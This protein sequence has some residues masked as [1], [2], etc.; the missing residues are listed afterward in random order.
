MHIDQMNR[1]VRIPVAP[2]RII[3]LVPSQTEFLYDIGLGDRLVGVTKF[4][5][6][7]EHIRQEKSIVGG[8]K[9]FKI[10]RIR[11]L[12][13][14]LIIGNKEENIKHL[15]E[16]LAEEFPVWMSDIKT[17]DDATEMMQWVGEIT[18]TISETTRIVEKIHQN[19]N[20][21]DEQ[22]WSTKRVAYFIWK[23]P[24]M[25]AGE[26]NIITHLMGRLKWENVFSS[27]L[28]F[29]TNGN[30]RYPS[31]KADDLVDAQPDLILLSSEPYPFREKHLI[32]FEQLCPQA[33][34]LLVDGEM[35]SW[36][37]SRLQYAP[38]YFKSLLSA[39]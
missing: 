26:D 21:L 1:S 17:V 20:R 12:K 9:D 14:D 16:A 15:I 3:S 25:V 35:F 2:Q 32:E 34:V 23:K 18:D 29:Q 19:F 37:G 13:P 10:D 24:L 5:V 38:E 7:P 8:T 39:I 11:Q 4:C 22:E 31:I 33:K 36:Y 30:T 6:H 27:E 28:G